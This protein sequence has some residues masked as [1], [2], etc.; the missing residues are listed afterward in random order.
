M[1]GGETKQHGAGFQA[2]FRRCPAEY[3]KS[4]ENDPGS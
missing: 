1:I 3:D 4:E 2:E